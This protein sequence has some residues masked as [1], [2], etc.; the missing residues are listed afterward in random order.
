MLPVNIIKGLQR[1][2]ELMLLDPLTGESKTV[3]S[4]NELNKDLYEILCCC[5]NYVESSI[6]KKPLDLGLNALGD[7]VSG[8]CPHCLQSVGRLVN[9]VNLKRGWFCEYCGQAFD[10]RVIA[11]LVEERRRYMENV[12]Y[13]V[14]NLVFGP[15]G[16]IEET[17][18][19]SEFYNTYDEA[20]AELNR[21]ENEGY[22]DLIIEEYYFGEE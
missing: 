15:F 3:E 17:I 9:E 11:E 7:Y 16:E 10:N 13:R 2:R 19:Q 22:E 1:H 18:A 6:T 5:E 14:V 12:G 8:F 21:L 4:L 20:N